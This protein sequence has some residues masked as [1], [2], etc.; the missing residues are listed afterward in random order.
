MAPRERKRSGKQPRDIEY[1]RRGILRPRACLPSPGTMKYRSVTQGL[2]SLGSLQ[3]RSPWWPLLVGAVLT[4]IGALLATRLELRTRFDQLLPDHQASVVELRRLSERTGGQSSVYV[5]LEGTD[6]QRLRAVGDEL[7]PRLRALG[8]PIVTSAEDGVQNAR[9][10]LESRSGLF[11]GLPELQKL[12]DDVEARWQWEVGQQTG[13]NLDDDAPPPPVTAEGVRKSLGVDKGTEASKRFPDGYYQSADGHAVV[14]VARS[15]AVSGDLARAQATLDHV[16]AVVGDVLRSPEAAGVKAGY[17][18]DLVTGLAEYGAVRRDLVDVGALG[19]GLVLGV[20]LLFFMRLRALVAMGLTIAAG[21]A[22][23]F[24]ATQLAIGHL[25]VATGFLF[26]IVAGNGINFG[27]I[28]MARYFEERRAGRSPADA[29][30]LA[31]EHTWPSTLTAAAAAA[32][33]Y[34]SLWV[35]DFRAFKH[36]AFIGGFGMVACWVA[37]YT[38]L[39]S[40]LLLFERVRPFAGNEATLFGRLRMRG[41]R[42]DGLFGATVRRAPRVLVAAGAALACVGV[43]LAIPYVRSDPMEYDMGHLQSNLGQG[44]EMYRVSH[45]AGG[46]LGANLDSAMAVALDRVDQVDPFVQTLEARRTAAPEN[47]K[48]FEAIHSILDFVPRD[49]GKKLPLLLELRDKLE[50][51]HGRGSITEA[52]WKEL[53]ANLPPEDLRTFGIDDLPDDLARPFTEKSGIRGRLVL[54]EPTAGKSDSDLRYLMRWADSFRETQ[55]PNGDV[56]H[57]SGRAVIF[58][59]MLESVVH[60]IP[61][62]IGLSLGMTILAVLVTFRRRSSAIAVLAAL[63]VGIAWV[64][65]GLVVAG[66]RIHFFNFI[67]LPITFGIGVDYAVNVVQR[68]DADGRRG[69]LDV[70]RSTGGPVILCS[71]TTTLGYLALLGSINQAIRGLGLLAV[72]G[73]IACLLAAVLV[74]P[75]ALVLRERALRGFA[76]SEKIRDAERPAPS[77]PQLSAP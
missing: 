36:F 47:A 14:V 16:K 35:T 61:K 33:A 45:L 2:R 62:C 54:I 4:V 32:A 73:E 69:I 19:I 21:I 60:D 11:A 10:F 31:H 17:A 12:H 77:Q 58:A 63:A 53:Q 30:L 50:R 13:S 46:I 66:V 27:I 18:G 7:V 57:G 68:Y 67:A 70:L 49:Q 52:D 65:L 22:W 23:T 38:L 41:V 64:T 39:P 40:I 56:V 48:P 75:A 6:T 55:L 24:G 20:V 26:S 29:V 8:P 42:Y 76:A 59:D 37:T 5:L 71:F 44:A 9:A 43:A 34:S 72:M 74:L 1:G 3:V 25:N 51:A 15:A 28:Y